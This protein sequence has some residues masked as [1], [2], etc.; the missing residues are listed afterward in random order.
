MSKVYDEVGTVT[1][2]EGHV[3]VS[4]PNGVAV[5]LT[6]D[7]ASAMAEQLR[8]AARMAREQLPGNEGF[9]AG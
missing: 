9:R 5:T 2:S 7:A 1:A 4:G 3:L 6:A 8:E